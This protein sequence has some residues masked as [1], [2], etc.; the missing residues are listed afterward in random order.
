MRIYTDED[1]T[2]RAETP[3]C[4]LLGQFLEHDVQASE[5][6]AQFYLDGLAEGASWQG[7]GNACRV[8]AEGDRVTIEP[9]HG[10]GD[11][12]NLPR[13]TVRDA[14]TAWRDAVRSA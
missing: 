1:G 6:S 7:A 2:L 10:M 8:R 9:L 13:T 14:L 11:A 12:V 5:Q 4:P 3:D